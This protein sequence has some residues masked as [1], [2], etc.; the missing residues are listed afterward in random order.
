M[1]LL[2]CYHH[3]FLKIV[4]NISHELLEQVFFDIV[5]A[6]LKTNYLQEAKKI[7]TL[8]NCICK[9]P[10][11]FLDLLMYISCSNMPSS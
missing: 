8:K 4:T 2:V 11:L 7:P 10:I 5:S 3:K 9:V 1:D 6:A